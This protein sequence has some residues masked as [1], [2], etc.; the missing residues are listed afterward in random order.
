VTT[1]RYLFLYRS[2]TDAPRKTPS[3]A[4]MQEAMAEFKAWKTKFS[5]EIVDMGDK[6]TPVG[7]VCRATGV[8]DGPY[9]E[10][11]EVIGGYMIVE[12]TSLEQALQIAQEG[13]MTRQPGA[14]VEVRELAGM[15]QKISG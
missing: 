9:I 8:S 11:K 3:P 2:P 13:P 10:G 7:G 12:T 1:T 4:E 15:S 6:L 14:S 5:R